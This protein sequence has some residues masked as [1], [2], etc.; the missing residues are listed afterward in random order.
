MTFKRSI[1]LGI[2]SFVVGI[3]ATFA[4]VKIGEAMSDSVPMFSAIK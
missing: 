4:A 1:S 2:I 3:I